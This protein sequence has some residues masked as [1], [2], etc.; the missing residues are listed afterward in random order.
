[1]E[2]IKSDQLTPAVV[3]NLKAV[4]SCNKASKLP[5]KLREM[6]HE[7]L[8]ATLFATYREAVEERGIPYR[9]IT[10]AEAGKNL[11]DIIKWMNNQKYRTTLFLQGSFG[12][13]KTTILEILYALYYTAGERTEFCTARGLLDQYRQSCNNEYNKYDLYMRTTILFIDDLGTERVQ[14]RHYGDELTPIQDLI[15]YRYERQLTNIIT[16]N[17]PM[18]KIKERYG[19]RLRDRCDEMCSIIRFSGESYRGLIGKPAE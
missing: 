17:L 3:K 1:M 5:Q 11:V 4:M 18:E 6:D 19:G 2:I 10:N 9:D 14:F 16:T 7:E 13:G 12:T 15:D 8:L